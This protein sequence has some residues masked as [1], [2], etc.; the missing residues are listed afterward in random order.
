MFLASFMLKKVTVGLSAVAIASGA[1]YHLSD[2]DITE[3]KREV[4]MLAKEINQITI[5]VQKNRN[6]WLPC[7]QRVRNWQT[8][9]DG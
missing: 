5:E 3:L 7:T 2:K 4:A 6:A 1:A 9:S 8:C